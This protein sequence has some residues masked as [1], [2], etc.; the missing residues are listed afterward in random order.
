M[1]V[2]VCRPELF[3]NLCLVSGVPLLLFRTTP[4]SPEMRPVADVARSVVCVCMSDTRCAETTGRTGLDAVWGR[5][6]V[7]PGTSPCIN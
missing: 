4:L 3:K 2:R 6:Y 5:S 7:G 1:S